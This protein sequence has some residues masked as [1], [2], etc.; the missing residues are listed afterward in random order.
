M[1][2]E[3]VGQLM[4]DAEGNMSAFLAQEKV[5]P[6]ASGDL[7]GG[8]EAEIRAAFNGFFGYFGHY[9]ANLAEGTVTHHIRGAS[10]PNWAGVE[11]VRHFRADGER[12]VLSM[13]PVRSEG[14]QVT[15]IAI[16]ER[17]G[18]A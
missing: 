10:F 9:S 8:T 4:Y 7:Q 14:R 11:Q 12:L 15:I 5:P 17:A 3:V 1:G 16:W 6:F 2:R 18:A 13:P